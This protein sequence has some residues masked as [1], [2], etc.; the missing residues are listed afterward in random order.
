M[1]HFDRRRRSAPN[2]AATQ[3]MGFCSVEGMHCEIEFRW[4]QGERQ[5]RPGVIPAPLSELDL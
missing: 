5:A 4:A 3:S 2:F 1:T